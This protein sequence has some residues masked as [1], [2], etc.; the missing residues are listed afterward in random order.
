MVFRVI[1]TVKGSSLLLHYAIRCWFCITGFSFIPCLCGFWFFFSLSSASS[2][3]DWVLQSC[4]FSRLT[5]SSTASRSKATL[6]SCSGWLVWWWGIPCVCLLQRR[7]VFPSCLKGVFSGYNGLGW[8]FDSFRSLDTTSPSLLVWEASA[9]Q[10][11]M[12]QK[13]SCGHDCYFSLA[14]SRVFFSWTRRASLQWT[15]KRNYLLFG[16]FWIWACASFPVIGRFWSGFSS[17]SGPKG[18]GICCHFFPLFL[19]LIFNLL[20]IMCIHDE[21]SSFCLIESV[22][23]VVHIFYIHWVLWI[24]GFCLFL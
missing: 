6:P 10:P 9:E 8:K 18:L 14:M 20:K 12:T 16:D 17:L 2:Q 23:K 15:R 4:V 1:F 19:Y 3:F 22:A 11:F 24:P 7:L 13:G 5:L 21:K